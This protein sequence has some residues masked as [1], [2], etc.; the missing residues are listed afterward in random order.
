MNTE[1][2][3]HTWS[4][5]RQVDTNSSDVVNLK[6]REIPDDVKDYLDKFNLI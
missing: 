2:D 4:S 6:S 1:I 3:V 5:S